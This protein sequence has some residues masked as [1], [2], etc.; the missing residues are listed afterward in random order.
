MSAL[1]R[2]V[3][4]LQPGDRHRPLLRW[5]LLVVAIGLGLAAAL[6]HGLL[7]R[8]VTADPTGV[9]LVIAALSAFGLGQGGVQIWR[10][11]GLHDEADGGPAGALALHLAA[12][13]EVGAQDPEAVQHALAARLGRGCGFGWFV[14][15]TLLS[16]GL[17]GTVIGFIMMLAPLSGLDVGD[18]AAMQAA[19]GAMS[20]G[21]AVALHTTLAGLVGS[22][23]LRLQAYMID[24]ALAELLRRVSGHTR[25]TA[26]HARPPEARHAA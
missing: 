15:D 10:L 20:A 11:S 1:A 26:D 21:M 25:P 19:L 8:V 16:L 2:R 5:L 3:A 7:Q 6:H 17:L 9:T 14:A 13:R 4:G 24:D 22:L 12:A 18:I 23:V